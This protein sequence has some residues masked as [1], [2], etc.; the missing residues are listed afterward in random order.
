MSVPSSLGNSLHKDT[1]YCVLYNDEH[2]SYDHVI[3]ALQRS[4]QCDHR[5]AHTHTALIDKEVQGVGDYLCQH[6]RWCF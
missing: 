3:Y 6:V 1:Y 5:E 2:H 4:L